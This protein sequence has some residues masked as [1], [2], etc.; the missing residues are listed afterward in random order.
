MTGNYSGFF[1]S[2]SYDDLFLVFCSKIQQ[3]SPSEPAKVYEKTASRRTNGLFNPTITLNKLKEG[4][5][6][7][8]LDQDGRKDLIKQYLEVSRYTYDIRDSPST[9]ALLLKHLTNNKLE[10]IY[11]I[12]FFSSLNN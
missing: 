2:L 11:E 1:I 10:V 6:P 3:Y 7:E 12:K 5:P 9:R 8:Y 4:T